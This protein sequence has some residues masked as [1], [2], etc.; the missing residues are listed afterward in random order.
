[1]YQP[2]RQVSVVPFMREPIPRNRSR[3]LFQG[4][5]NIVKPQ[6]IV[7]L[8]CPVAESPMGNDS[9]MQSPM[10]TD[11]PTEA[12]NQRPRLAS[13]DVH[14]GFNPISAND[15]VSSWSASS[16]KQLASPGSMSD[17]VYPI[18]SVVS[19]DPTQTPFTLPGR[20]S[21]E[22]QDYFPPGAAGVDIATGPRSRNR[23]AQSVSEHDGPRGKHENKPA[24][25]RYERK[26]SMSKTYSDDRYGGA[27][28][29]LFSDATS[30]KSNGGT[31]SAS[32]HGTSGTGGTGKQSS[33]GNAS[34]AESI[35][36]LITAR[37]KHIVTS[38]GRKISH[39][40]TAETIRT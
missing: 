3:D 40:H 5:L 15:G 16:D 2:S 17:R 37:F 7:V 18:R 4:L 29:Q 30:D 38:E 9:P 6:T 31:N 13:S 22:H 1:M 34:E 28:M 21:A 27:R 39:T 11:P 24:H 26:G 23:H 25:N 33:L 12:E 14:R 20:S 36:G 32:L 19:V 8:M 10:T 35:P